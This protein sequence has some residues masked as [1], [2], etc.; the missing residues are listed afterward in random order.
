MTELSPEMK[1]KIKQNL[2]GKR[3]ASHGG[4]R[5]ENAKTIFVDGIWYQSQFRAADACRISSVSIYL[6]FKKSGGAPCMVK[7]HIL[8]SE[9]WIQEHKEA[10]D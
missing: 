1:A 10:L 3:A 6:A 5:K 8:V 7:Q 2:G 9:A 4:Y